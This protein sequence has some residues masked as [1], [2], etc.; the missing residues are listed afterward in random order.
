MA[1]RKQCVFNP[2]KMFRQFHLCLGEKT[3]ILG[4]LGFV[5]QGV[6]LKSKR[7]LKG[8]FFPLKLTNKPCLDNPI[9]D[10]TI[11]CVYIYILY[12]IIKHIYIYYT[13]Y[14]FR[15]TYIYDIKHDIHPFSSM[16][17]IYIYRSIPV[18]RLCYTYQILQTSYPN[19]ENP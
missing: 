2:L 1:I 8:S 4:R 17:D 9:Y 7:S 19:E 11:I 13:I 6:N 15:Y 5:H 16:Y 12:H 10:I 14:I 3:T 18:L